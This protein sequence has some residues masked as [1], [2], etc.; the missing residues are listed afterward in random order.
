MGLL[1]TARP[2]L[3]ETFDS[4]ERA[5]LAIRISTLAAHDELVAKLNDAMPGLSGTV[6]DAH[7]ALDAAEK[8]QQGATAAAAA[9]ALAVIVGDPSETPD[10]RTGAARRVHLAE[11]ALE[12]ATAALNLARQHLRDADT[13]RERL[14][15][16]AKA[17]A[18][19][20]LR[21]SPAVLG[22][23]VKLE[24]ALQE[25]A[26]AAGEFSW[27]VETNV[28]ENVTASGQTLETSQARH[29]QRRRMY[30]DAQQWGELLPNARALMNAE[31]W[32]VALAAL[33]QDA[34]APIPEVA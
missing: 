21:A 8:A 10:T 17:A 26:V 5:E 4:P 15:A 31:R 29:L 30:L 12:A 33:M 22:T 11:D 7:E 32:K 2:R 14:S 16:E 34:N 24:R 27:L 6:S 23:V 18:I 13:L 3:V 1:K 20:V 19:A 28:L 25:A 9:H